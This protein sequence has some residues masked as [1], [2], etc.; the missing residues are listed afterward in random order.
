MRFGP[1]KAALLAKIDSIS[2]L[3]LASI[4]AVD[5][6]AQEWGHGLRFT[7]YFHW[8]AKDVRFKFEIWR[9]SRSDYS[10]IYIYISYTRQSR[11][12]GY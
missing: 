4:A 6:L 3:C 11:G 5:G 8:I 1:W 7:E 9:S 2:P 10:H 12:G